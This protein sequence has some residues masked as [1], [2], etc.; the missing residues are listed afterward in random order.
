MRLFRSLVLL[1]VSGPSMLGCAGAAGPSAAIGGAN[2]PDSAHYSGGFH[3][4]R[5]PVPAGGVDAQAPLEAEAVLYRQPGLVARALSGVR[6]GQRGV[7][8]LFYLGFAGD[9]EQ[10]VFKNE[11][12]LAERILARHF[13]ARG[14]TL[15]LFSDRQGLNRYPLATVTN[16]REALK[17]VAAR[18]DRDEDILFLFV[19][20]HG[21]KDH[22]ISVRLGELPLQDLPAAELAEALAEAGIKWKVIVVSACYSGGFIAPLRDENSMVITA[23]RADRTSFGCSDEAELTYFGKA[24]L[25]ESL[26]T[27]PS[28]GA[29]FARA[30][31]LV[32]A[33]EV[34][35]EYTPSEPQIAYRPAILRKLGEWRRAVRP[36]HARRLLSATVH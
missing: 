16:L 17:G 11:V 29:A 7:V 5:P 4:G 31:R 36:P 22:R 3:G 25:Q 27:T 24:F 18:M 10:R 9:G 1:I 33:M 21:S 30:A 26:A 8:E 13:G 23:A 14:R 20:S 35:Q 15:V 34:K 32:R 28:F 2:L 6:S 12:L 19:T